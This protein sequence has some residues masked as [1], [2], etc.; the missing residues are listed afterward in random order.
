M[1]NLD[2]RRMTEKKNE[3]KCLNHIAQEAVSIG[4]NVLHLSSRLNKPRELSLGMNAHYSISS[5]NVEKLR[6]SQST[7]HIAK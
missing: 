4:G 1:R 7:L 3:V 5:T 2:R 6:A